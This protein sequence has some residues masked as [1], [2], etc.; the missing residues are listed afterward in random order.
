MESILLLYSNFTLVFTEKEAEANTSTYQE[1][2][3]TSPSDVDRSRPLTSNTS[4]DCEIQRLHDKI[5][6][7]EK[8]LKQVFCCSRIT[9]LTQLLLRLILVVLL[10]V[11]FYPDTKR[12]DTWPEKTDSVSTDH[13]EAL[14]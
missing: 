6:D 13:E 3:E 10:M 8:K 7:L 11:L 4:N 12:Q 1:Y 9:S 5:A 2:T 14:Q